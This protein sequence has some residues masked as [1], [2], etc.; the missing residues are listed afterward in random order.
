[1]KV[2]GFV[3]LAA[4]AVLLVPFAAP[5]YSGTIRDDRSDSLYL[6]LGAAPVYASVGHVEGATRRYNFQASGT[7]IAPD[8]VLTAAHVVKDAT[9]LNFTVGG[10]T[11]TGTSWVAHK[12]F[13]NRRLGAG[14]D[15]GL[16]HLNAPVEN[17]T[18]A[19]RYTGYDELGNVATA[20]GYGMTGTG[21]TGAYMP[22]GQKRAGQNMVDNFYPTAESTPNII[23]MDFDQPG[24]PYESSFGS[25]LPLDLEYLCAPGDSGGGLFA[26]LGFGEELIGVHSFG[27][28]LLDGDP[29]ADYGD[30]SGD[31][32]V[33]V[34]NSWIDGAMDGQ[35]VNPGKGGGKKNSRSNFVQ[36]DYEFG[37]VGNVIP[38]PST[39]VLLTMAA[40]GML[41]YMWNRRRS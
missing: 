7:L 11:Y 20:V 39:F 32:R 10:T 8:W 19:T 30:A 15:I 23:L 41:T 34:F 33:S 22:A 24:D 13:K 3:H 26:D 6:D 36:G 16:I 17:I 12:E 37:Y 27:W 5:A 28:G 25:T 40:L 4:V 14:Y 35:I 2:I 18:P 21:L 31:T 29:N 1:M 9:S 38:E